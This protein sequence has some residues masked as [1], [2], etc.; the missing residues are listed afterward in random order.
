MV[1]DKIDWGNA[2]TAAHT[3]TSG[4]P[5]AGP[6]GLFDSGLFPPGKTFSYQFSEKGEV[7]YY[8]IVHP[9]MTGVVTVTAGF[10]VISNVG[11][12]AGD[13]KTTFNVQY[14]YDRLISSAKI[15]Q[16]SKAITFTMVGKAVEGANSVMLMLPDKLIK[17]PYVIFVDGNEIMEFKENKNGGITTLTIPVGPKAE[18]LTILGSS[19]VPEF[20][21][22]AM[23]ILGVALV[24][25]IALKS[26]LPISGLSKF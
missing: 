8:C 3:V 18:Q 23:M 7:P 24:S 19:V 1:G 14:Q 15:D 10:K 25:I 12:D 16:E 9:W 13:G 5:D 22:I 6:S 2:D 17:G 20:G 4:T 11:A 21:T 26:R